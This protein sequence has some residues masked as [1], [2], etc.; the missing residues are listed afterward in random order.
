[1]DDKKVTLVENLEIEPLSDE[2]LELIGGGDCDSM[3]PV[4]CSLAGCSS[5]TPYPCPASLLRAYP[6]ARNARLQAGQDSNYT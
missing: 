4:C 1:M 5:Q 3:G 2:A 6:A